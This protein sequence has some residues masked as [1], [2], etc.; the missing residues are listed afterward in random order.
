MV[1]ME[2]KERIAR[3]VT[4]T[5]L[6]RNGR[7]LS[8]ISCS[9]VDRFLLTEKRRSTNERAQ[10]DLFVAFITQIQRVCGFDSEDWLDCVSK[11]ITFTGVMME[12]DREEIKTQ[13]ETGEPAPID[14]V[15]ERVEAEM[16]ELE[17]NAKQQVADGLQDKEL[18]KEAARLKRES[19]ESKE[20]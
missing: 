3:S 11:P 12:L 17:A 1:R 5:G 19:E 9:F 7:V 16:K 14:Q 6:S 18:A 10:Y 8:V 4:Q 15:E 13:E 2:S 20:D